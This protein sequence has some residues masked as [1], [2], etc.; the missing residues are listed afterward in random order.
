MKMQ[1]MFIESDNL[2]NQMEKKIKITRVAIL[3]R[4][5]YLII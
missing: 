4:W 3:A 1:W 2:S 5:G